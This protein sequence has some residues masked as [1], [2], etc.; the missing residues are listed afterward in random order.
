MV[1]LKVHQ[2]S[3]VPLKSLAVYLQLKQSPLQRLL[4][5]MCKGRCLNNSNR[6]L[7]DWKDQSFVSRPGF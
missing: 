5:T 4:T 2:L 7:M 6:S 3:L 1:L